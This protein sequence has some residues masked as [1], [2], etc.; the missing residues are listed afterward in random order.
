MASSSRAQMRSRWLDSS[1]LSLLL[2]M[3]MLVFVLAVLPR[4]ADSLMNG[5]VAQLSPPTL[6][7]AATEA[8][9]RSLFIADMHADSLMWPR[10]NLLEHHDYGHVDLPRLREGNVALQ[11]FT[12]VTGFA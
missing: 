6:P 11:F 10:R 3:T 12:I 8:L 1:Y 5:L 4:E 9:H 7:D 2:A